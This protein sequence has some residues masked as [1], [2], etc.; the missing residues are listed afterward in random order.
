MWSKGYN[1]KQVRLSLGLSVSTWDRWKKA[2]KENTE[3]ST[4]VPVRTIN[5]WSPEV[6]KEA[7]TVGRGGVRYRYT[8]IE[9]YLGKGGKYNPT[10]DS[11]IWN[12]EECFF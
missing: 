1:D 11:Y 6:T 8:D 4:E 2:Y 9:K 10:R 7:N 3:V 5:N 12:G